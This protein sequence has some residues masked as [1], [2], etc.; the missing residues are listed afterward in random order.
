MPRSKR[1]KEVRLTKTKSKGLEGKGIIISKLK[2]AIEDHKYVYVF[3]VENPRNNLMKDV[4]EEWKHSQF[5]MGKN[6]ILQLALGKTPEEE[7]ANGLS[8]LA[9]KLRGERGLLITDQPKEET[10]QWFKKHKVG[11]YARSGFT[12]TQTVKLDAGPLAQFS[13]A[14]EPH[15]R[16]LGLPTSLSRGIVTLLKDHTVCQEGDVL[17]PEQCRILK[18]LEI[19][20]ASFRIVLK[21]LWTKKTGKVKKLGG[22][23]GAAQGLDSTVTEKETA[24]VEKM[25]EN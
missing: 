23:K 19:Q 24:A 21:F 11:E 6:N 2:K 14:L 18:L 12:A 8:S 10:V 3:E 16:Q 25:E 5:F 13:H 22:K 20:M 7:Q 4:R 9:E 1:N 17:T 15:L